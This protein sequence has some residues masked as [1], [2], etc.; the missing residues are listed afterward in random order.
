MAE[1]SPLVVMNTVQGSE[2]TPEEDSEVAEEDVIDVDTP[3]RE[4]EWLRCLFE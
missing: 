4:K 3:G 1:K 2:A